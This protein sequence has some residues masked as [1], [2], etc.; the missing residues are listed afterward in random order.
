LFP[1]LPAKVSWEKYLPIIDENKGFNLLATAI[2]KTLFH[3]SEEAT[4][5]RRIK[6]LCSIV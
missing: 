4:D 1:S 3:Q 2:E 5:C 6:V